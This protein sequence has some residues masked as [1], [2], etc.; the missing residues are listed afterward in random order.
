M[1]AALIFE[2]IIF[3]DL[4]EKNVALGLKHSKLLL[5][6]SNDSVGVSR[7]LSCWLGV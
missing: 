5:T 1:I 2:T 7:D 4:T 3:I 6:Y